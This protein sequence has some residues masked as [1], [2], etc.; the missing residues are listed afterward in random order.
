[1]IGARPSPV[2]TPSVSERVRQR[3]EASESPGALPP[4]EP[5]RLVSVKDPL[6]DSGQIAIA[7]EGVGPGSN[8]ILI[9]RCK[10]K[11]TEVYVKTGITQS[12]DLKDGSANEADLRMRFD[13]EKGRRITGSL[14][15]DH[16]EV[17]LPGSSRFVEELM[18]H[19]R[20]LLGYRD[21]LGKEV[22]LTFSVEG[23]TERVK[24]I[25]KACGW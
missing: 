22:Q 12:P 13:A 9:I 10:R 2:P 1:M 15:A 18:A 8:P 24:P 6:D 25:R 17:F 23:L 11:R 16:E 5:W 19:Q 20:L 14:S 7:R 3:L 4:A 21:Y